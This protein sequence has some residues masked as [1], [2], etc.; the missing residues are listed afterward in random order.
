[1]YDENNN[2][3]KSI[4]ETEILMKTIQSMR[5]DKLFD[6]LKNNQKSESYNKIVLEN[7]GNIDEDELAMPI[8][9]TIRKLM[10]N[11][12][13]N[14]KSMDCKDLLEWAIKTNSLAVV[15]TIIK[16]DAISKTYLEDENFSK[17]ISKVRS[18]NVVQELEKYRGF[19]K[20]MNKGTTKNDINLHK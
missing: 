14:L 4:K 16:C 8:V 19:I 13:E 9:K 12:T 10:E 11:A 5:L 18:E 3:G 17:L 20:T 1:M 2:L 15:K 7:L 6:M